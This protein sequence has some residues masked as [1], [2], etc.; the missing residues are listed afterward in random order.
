[1]SKTPLT[2]I[3]LKH[4]PEPNLNS[5]GVMQ[6]ICF[7]GQTAGESMNKEKKHFY[8]SYGQ[9]IQENGLLCRSRGGFC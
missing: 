3:L 5:K 7:K 2:D 1:V 8:Q 9:Q 6:R 4:K